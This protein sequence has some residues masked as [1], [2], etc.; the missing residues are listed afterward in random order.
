MIWPFNKPKPKRDLHEE[1][2]AAVSANV[3]LERKL[4]VVRDQRGQVLAANAELSRKLA[5]ACRER[6]DAMAFARISGEILT[7]RTEALR[8]I[9]AQETPGANGTV[10]RMARLAREALEWPTT[11]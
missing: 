11:T 5:E 7:R 3:E 2:A 8:T 9:A 6:E 1:L 4:A 10:K